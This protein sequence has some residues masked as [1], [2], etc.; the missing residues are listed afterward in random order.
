MDEKHAGMLQEYNMRLEKDI[1]WTDRIEMLRILEKHKNVLRKK[2][3]S[4]IHGQ[5]QAQ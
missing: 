3:S 5:M 2:I 1:P 4:K